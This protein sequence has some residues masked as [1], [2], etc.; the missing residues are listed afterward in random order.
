MRLRP[1]CNDW[2]ITVI[3]DLYFNG[4]HMSFANRYRYL[5]PRRELSDNMLQYEV[6]MPMVALVATAV[7]FCPILTQYAN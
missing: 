1:Y 7:S 4:G 5:F 6:P 3:Q 2:I